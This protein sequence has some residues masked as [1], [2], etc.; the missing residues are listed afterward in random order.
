MWRLPR[1]EKSTLGS[2]K[3]L[4]S[5]PKMAHSLFMTK[6]ELIEALETHYSDLLFSADQIAVSEALTALRRGTVDM[7][8]AKALLVLARA[9]EA[10]A[11]DLIADIEGY[12]ALAWRVTQS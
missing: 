12:V 9:Y 4:D 1:L 6:T 10:D 2:E 8:V 7:A 11:A 3:E 5:A